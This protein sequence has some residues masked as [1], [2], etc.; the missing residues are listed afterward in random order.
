MGRLL[1]RIRLRL[2]TGEGHVVDAPGQV[3]Q[4]DERG[5]GH[6]QDP[7]GRVEAA[8]NFRLNRS[9]MYCHLRPQLPHTF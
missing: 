9:S 3:G 6:R 2:P 7:Q 1:P 8:A 5:G 4:E